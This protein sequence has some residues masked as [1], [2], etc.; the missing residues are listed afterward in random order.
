VSAALLGLILPAVAPAAD[1]Q[2]PAA[3]SDLLVLVGSTLIEREQSHGYWEAAVT[4]RWP[5]GLRVRNLGWSGDTVWGDARAGFGTAKDGFAQLKA[6]VLGLKPSLIVVAYG[7]NESQAGP[8]GREAFRRGLND[9]LDAFPTEARVVLM[10]PPRREDLGRPLPDPAE[11]NRCLALYSQTIRDVAAARKLEVIDLLAETARL[12]KEEPKLRLTDNGVHFTA[13]G[14]E[15]TAVFVAQSLGLK[16]PSWR[17]SLSAGKSEPVESHGAKVDD[18]QSS[19]DAVRFSAIDHALPDPPPPGV[20]TTASARSPSQRVLQIAGL[21][22]G[23][24]VLR[25]DQRPVAVA[26]SADW[27][28]GVALTGAE[29]PLDGQ[30]FPVGGADIPVCRF[31]PAFDQSEELRRTLLRKNELY[32]HRWRPQNETYLFGFRKHEQGQN[33]REVPLFEPL[34]ADQEAIVQRLL[35][36]KRHYYELLPK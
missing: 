20:P 34:V 35:A 14:Y 24:Y 2:I 16:S 15:R 29:A 17:V 33:A 31:P 3:D 32:F 4:L 7:A 9:M 10:T 22:D 26:S 5:R 19:R 11:A 28:K 1:P 36:P 6:G 25:I 21:T 27:A 23:D 30:D 18:L 13:A 12:A 8:E